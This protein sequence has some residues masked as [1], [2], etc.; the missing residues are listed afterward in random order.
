VGAC[1][2]LCCSSDTGLDGGVELID[3]LEAALH[4]RLCCAHRIW[5]LLWRLRSAL[6][7]PDV[8][9]QRRLLLQE[10]VELSRAEAYR[11]RDGKAGGVVGAMLRTPC[12]WVL[13][14]DMGKYEL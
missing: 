3:P 8:R 12:V 9:F 4:T 2:G 5:R 6:P 7:F 1:R 14:L 10:M 11:S 13:V